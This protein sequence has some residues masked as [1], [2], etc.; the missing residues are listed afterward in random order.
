MDRPE[1]M[2]AFNRDDL[3][4]SETDDGHTGFNSETDDAQVG[5]AISS[6][7]SIEGVEQHSSEFWADSPSPVAA[8]QYTAI[9]SWMPR[10]MDNGHTG[11]NSET[12][13]G[14]M[15]LDMF[16]GHSIEGVEQHTLEVCAP[17]Q[18]PVA[19]GQDPAIQPWTSQESMMD[20][21]L[22]DDQSY[23]AGD[24]QRWIFN[25]LHTYQD[26]LS[27]GSS[28]SSANVAG[29]PGGLKVY[30]RNLSYNENKQRKLFSS[31]EAELLKNAYIVDL[32]ASKPLVSSCDEPGPST[33]NI[34]GIK[35]NIQLCPC[36]PGDANSRLAY[37]GAGWKKNATRKAP[38]GGT[39]RSGGK[40]AKTTTQ[41]APGAAAAS[42][43]HQASILTEIQDGAEEDFFAS[44]RS[45]DQTELPADDCKDADLNPAKIKVWGFY[46]VTGKSLKT[47]ESLCKQPNRRALAKDKE[48]T[49]SIRELGP[50]LYIV[51]PS[52]HEPVKLKNVLR[53]LVSSEVLSL[54]AVL[55]PK[56]KY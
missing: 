16:P 9:Q 41:Q 48:N 8:G 30:K 19:D 28:I 44:S 22:I 45:A 15:G 5:S 29:S 34:P 53:T 50:V 52:S 55:V 1:C 46:R 3:L 4:S 11:F 32:M 35:E 39:E 36:P 25:Q 17:A 42:Q 33:V 31:N 40:K 12:N 7:Y 38:P 49:L 37:I 6:S 47:I 20:V 51:L 13:D 26:S 2:L 54:L 56:Y 24:L 14:R 23:S 21:I 27:S 10:E 43:L 18:A